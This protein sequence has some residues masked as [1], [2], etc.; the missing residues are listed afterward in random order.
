MHDTTQHLFSLK[1]FAGAQRGRPGRGAGPGRGR[2]RS[3]ERLLIRRRRRGR[4]RRRGGHRCARGAP[5]AAFGP[6][7]RR[8]ERRG[9]VARC[10]FT[11]VY[12]R[13]GGDGRQR[14]SGADASC[15]GQS[16]AAAHRRGRCWRCGDP[17]RSGERRGG[18]ERGC[19][20]CA[21]PSGKAAARE[22]A[23]P[24]RRRRRTTARS[25]GPAA[26]DRDGCRGYPLRLPRVLSECTRGRTRHR[27]VRGGADERAA[28][29]AGK[30][31]G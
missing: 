19:G 1:Q 8:R 11:P 17:N 15:A 9:G 5:R 18:F 14:T 27:G 26:E 7:R 16:A 29:V 30:P 20:R 3:D 25:G 24:R 28:R 12:R 4:G 21:V 2:R 23:A 10:E 13:G 6:D 31:R 22:A